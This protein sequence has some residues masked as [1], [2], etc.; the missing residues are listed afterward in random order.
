[1]HSIQYDREQDHTACDCRNDEAAEHDLRRLQTG[2][3]RHERLEG[4]DQNASD[5]GEG[6]GQGD[7]LRTEEKDYNSGAQFTRLTETPITWLPAR[8]YAENLTGGDLK[9]L[10]LFSGRF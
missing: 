7:A 2:V 8:T 1:V 5:S 9:K 10:S 6:S 4:D 3:A